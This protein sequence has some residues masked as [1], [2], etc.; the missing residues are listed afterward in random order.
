MNKFWIVYCVKNNG[1]F[2]MHETYELAEVSA[3][4]LAFENRNSEYVIMEAVATTQQP[5]PAI[6][7]LKL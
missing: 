3:K 5:V 1:I 6:D 7:I 2:P 4:R